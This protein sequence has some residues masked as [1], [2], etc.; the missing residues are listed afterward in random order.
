MRFET[1][2]KVNKT[3]YFLSLPK[4]LVIYKSRFYVNSR[5]F[6]SSLMRKRVDQSSHSSSPLPETTVACPRGNSPCAVELRVWIFIRIYESSNPRSRLISNSHAIS[7][8]LVHSLTLSS[9]IRRL[10][11]TRNFSESFYGLLAQCRWHC[12]VPVKPLILISILLVR[13][14]RTWRR[15]ISSTILTT[16]TTSK[17]SCR[18]IK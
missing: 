8:A 14:L 5:F 18:P 16:Q 11:P 2:K 3:H 1:R 15:N 13:Q 4:C 10:Y 17:V 9:V 7:S 6:S 12:K